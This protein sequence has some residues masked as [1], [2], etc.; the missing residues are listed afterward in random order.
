MKDTIIAVIFALFTG[1][2]GQ[3]GIQ[4]LA[5]KWRDD[6][7]AKK[8]DTAANDRAAAKKEAHDDHA[9]HTAALI[10]IRE[11]LQAMKACLEEN[12]RLREECAAKDRKIEQQAKVILQQAAALPPAV[13]AVPKA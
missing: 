12:A 4:A 7:L 3:A 9:A 2:G 6:K 1:L 5:K 13:K 10:A 11:E 8:V